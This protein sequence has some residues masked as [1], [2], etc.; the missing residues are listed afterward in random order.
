MRRQDAGG[1]VVNRIKELILRSG[2]HPG[3]PMPTEAHLVEEL[4]VARSSVR[5]AMRTLS[6]LDIVEVRHGHGTFVGRMS[7]APLVDGLLFRAR[8]N[9]GNDLRT[10]REVVQARI[11]LD[12]SIGPGLLAAWAHEDLAPARAEVERMREAF[13]AGRDFAEAD[14]A[15]HAAILAKLDNELMIQLSDAF[16]QVHTSAL[17]L[18][19]VPPAGDIRLTVEAHDAIVDALEVGDAEAYARAVH[20]HYAPLERALTAASD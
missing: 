7:L 19:D 11:A 3:D 2:L 14:Q 15:F 13:A 1:D 17:P 4:G 5:E 6:S 10:L 20:A 16:W 12:L 9:D 18:L 8:L